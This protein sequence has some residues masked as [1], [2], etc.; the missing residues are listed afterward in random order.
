[1]VAPKDGVRHDALILAVARGAWGFGMAGVGSLVHL[2]MR[3]CN[4]CAGVGITLGSATL[5]ATGADLNIIAIKCDILCT[6]LVSYS[7]PARPEVGNVERSFQ[8]TPSLRCS[9][10]R[11]RVSGLQ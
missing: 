10:W 3:L 5:T 6:E 4:V 8:T 2:W 1:M 7:W 9:V 11:N